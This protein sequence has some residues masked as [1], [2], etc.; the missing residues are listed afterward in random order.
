MTVFQNVVF[1]SRV[2]FFRRPTTR[3]RRRPTARSLHTQRRARSELSNEPSAA[4]NGH[5]G[6]EQQLGH[7]LGTV[8]QFIP[9]TR[10]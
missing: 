4:W 8:S 6:G 9:H 7:G 10:A 3:A 5:R 2:A 1:G